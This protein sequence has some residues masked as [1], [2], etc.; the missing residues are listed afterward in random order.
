MVPDPAFPATL[1]AVSGLPGALPR[2]RVYCANE[3]HA[4]GSEPLHPKHHLVCRCAATIRHNRVRDLLA[5]AL[6]Q[7][8]P[9]ARVRVEQSPDNNGLP[10]SRAWGVRGAMAPGDVTFE[11]VGQPP[12]YLDVVICARSAHRNM[13]PA[14]SAYHSKL[15]ARHRFLHPRGDGALSPHEAAHRAPH[16]NISYIPMAFSTLGDPAPLTVRTLSCLLGPGGLK[17]FLAGAAREIHVAQADVISRSRYAHLQGRRSPRSD[18]P[19]T[20]EEQVAPPSTASLS[21][22]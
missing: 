18:A 11:P 15:V 22:S 16:A 20:S 3:G 10:A 8:A 13:S 4:A 14:A 19:R 9:N 21:S 12:M 17:R 6:R 7:A 2:E 5:D 1:F